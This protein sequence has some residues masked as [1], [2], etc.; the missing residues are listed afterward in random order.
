MA[1]FCYRLRDAQIGY[2]RLTIALVALRQ[3]GLIRVTRSA[4]TLTV[5]VLP[6]EKKVQ[7][8]AAPILAK[9]KEKAV[10]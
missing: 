2:D 3:L 8:D 5:R 7:L 10:S 1:Y 9:F 6:A 4:D